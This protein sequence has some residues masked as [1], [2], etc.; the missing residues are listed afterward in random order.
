M[1]WIRHESENGGSVLYLTGAW[2]LG[3]LRPI[4]AALES[5][6]LSGPRPFVLDGSGLEE[7]DT[8]AAFI[9]YRYLASLGCTEAM[10]SLRAV[11]PRLERLLD[12]VRE[13]MQS[14]P[15]R[16]R[17]MHRGLLGRLG[18]AAVNLWRLLKAHN[19]FIGMIALELLDLVR[20]P[21]LFR[22]RETVSQFETVCLDAI[23]VVC[24][25]TFLIGVVLAYLLGVQAQRYGAG[26]F[27][28]DGV[29]LAICRELSPILVAV[30][31]AGRSGA[32]FTAQIGAMKVQE[33]IDAISTLGLSPVQV[34]VI[35]RL[36][37]ITAALPLLV[38]VG[39]LMG[40][41]GGIGVASWQLGIAPSVFVD[42]LHSVL[43]MSAFVVGVAKAPV[44]AVVIAAIACR[45]GLAVSR[46]ARSVGENTTS[47]VV[48]CI[49]S[50]IVLDAI[51]AV[52]LQRLGI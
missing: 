15:V 16:A 37:A 46:D 25:I 51:F 20:R 7:L 11:E 41:L 34:L 29:G 43:P 4:A 27:V 32:A 8:A 6:R 17:S 39:D 45:M 47:T 36:V 42:R 18:A 19:A 52:A 1:T 50:V 26:I 38:F 21:R 35:P 22:A 24:L 14:P 28:V 13:R 31:V 44:F 23:P 10:V 49:V 12:L 48:Q 30:V 2:R 9:L 3:D 33:E 40:I 5:L